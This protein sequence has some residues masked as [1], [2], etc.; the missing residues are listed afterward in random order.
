MTAV[1]AKP[2]FNAETVAQTMLYK[3]DGSYKFDFE[4][5]NGIKAGSEGDGENVVEGFYTY[6]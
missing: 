4:T 3:E 6:V 1:H 5:S 2:D